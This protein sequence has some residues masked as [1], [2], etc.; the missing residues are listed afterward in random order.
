[1]ILSWSLS[2][3]GTSTK[4]CGVYESIT[5]RSSEYFRGSK[6]IIYKFPA[7]I[8]LPLSCCSHIRPSVHLPEHIAKE[9]IADIISTAKVLEEHPEYL[10]RVEIFPEKGCLG[11]EMLPVLFL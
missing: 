1:M 4:A 11:L 9:Q 5:T 6:H 10:I 8:L 7:N 3:S 2:I